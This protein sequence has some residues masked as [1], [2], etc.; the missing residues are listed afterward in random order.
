[1]PSSLQEAQKFVNQFVIGEY[2][3]EE[4][5]EFL[6]WLSGASM[7]ELA[8]IAE[9]HES[10]EGEWVLPEGPSAAWVI[11]LEQKLH[12]AVAARREDETRRDDPELFM[13]DQQPVISIQSMRKLRWN[14]WTASAAV[15]ILSVTGTY[16]YLQ[17]TEP[18]LGKIA[19]REKLLSM[20]LVNPRG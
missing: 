11:Q 5:V 7:A 10:M 16:I 8:I 17:K 6:Q 14:F 3:P 2:T 18:K 13:D 19:D 12:E 1:M 4:H 20:T 9:R 15:V